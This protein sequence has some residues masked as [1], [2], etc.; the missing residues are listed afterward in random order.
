MI[1][2]ADL[3]DLE[4]AITRRSALKRI[5]AIGAGIAVGGE[6]VRQIELLAPRPVAGGLSMDMIRRCIVAIEKGSA[7][8]NTMIVS[9]AVANEMYFLHDGIFVARRDQ[10][11]RL[12]LA[13]SEMH[14][15]IVNVGRA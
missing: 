1:E 2:S 12:W 8:P 4:R 13:K 10:I 9:Q 15:A 5:F 6:L 11:H 3:L 7:T 14:G